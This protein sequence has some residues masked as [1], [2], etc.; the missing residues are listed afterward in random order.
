MI[1]FA[2]VLLALT[3]SGTAA[4]QGRMSDYVRGIYQERCLKQDVAACSELINAGGLS[5]GTRAL[6]LAVRGEARL[7]GERVAEALADLKEA[8]A[9]GETPQDPARARLDAALGVPPLSP[10]WRSAVQANLAEALLLSKD[11]A[12]ATAAVTLA[13]RL[14]AANGR[15]YVVRGR[16]QGS[17]NRWPAALADIDKG[18]SL[19]IAHSRL[20][21]RAYY[22]RAIVRSAL[23]QPP[24]AQIADFGRAIAADPELADSYQERGYLYQDLKRYEEALRDFDE[25]TRRAP[26]YAGGYNAACWTRAAYLKREFD[27]ARTQCDKALALKPEANTHDSAGLVA[28]QQQRWQDAWTHYD[29]AVKGDAKMASARFGRGVAAR[30]LGRRAEGD[31]DIAAANA[32]DAGIAAKYASYGQK[33]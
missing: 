3:V 13:I 20:R 5:D 19:G 6:A 4:A 22:L 14:N 32:M 17:D 2:V 21:A 26:R 23:K 8:A 11:K 10:A 16:I 18:L 24:E 12:G 31:A 30:K 1:R 33:P 9:I 15:A 29:K 28:L 7:A 27:T 25:L